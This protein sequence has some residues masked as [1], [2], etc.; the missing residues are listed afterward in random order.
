MS[1]SPSILIFQDHLST[2]GAARAAN[3]WADV[4]RKKERHVV[5]V[6]GDQSFGATRLL[7]GKP[8]RG[9]GRLVEAFTGKGRR[10]ERV[11]AG[12]KA[13]IQGQQLKAIWFHNIAG[14]GKWGWSEQMLSLARQY[15]PVVWTLH[16][17]WALG[18]S[19][20]SYW[21]EGSVV[22]SGR[23]IVG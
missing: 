3:R 2:G 1:Q 7:T 11:Q 15:A 18:D 23:W 19:S 21:A 20:E 10:K 14:G 12:I 9:W 22:E 8:S 17:M 5:Q 16:D 13:I 4:L 6:A